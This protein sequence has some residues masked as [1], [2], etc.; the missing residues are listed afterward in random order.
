ME[1]GFREEIPRSEKGFQRRDSRKDFRDSIPRRD[2]EEGFDEGSQIM[3]SEKQ[4]KEGIQ[5]KD[6]QSIR[7]I[8]TSLDPR[9]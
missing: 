4:F 5:R 6:S 9:K 8:G 1:E 3:V 7:S 2:S